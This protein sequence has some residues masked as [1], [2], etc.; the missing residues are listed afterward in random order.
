[1]KRQILLMVS[2]VIILAACKKDSGDNEKPV[3]N[4]T[5]PMANEQFTA[6]ETV[7]LQGSV[8]D[9]DELHE[10][11]IFVTNKSTGADLIHMAEHVDVKEYPINEV[12][13]VQA[14]VTYT[15]KVEAHDHVGNTAQVQLEVKG[16]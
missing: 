10:V 3:I 8:T 16:K 6:G 15:I 11:H 5:S 9:N 2:A 12:F 13:I 4:I 1:M 14:G 7:N